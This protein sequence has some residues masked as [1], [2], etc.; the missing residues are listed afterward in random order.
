M[1]GILIKGSTQA[2]KVMVL[3]DTIQLK[4]LAIEP[5]TCLRVEPETAETR[6]SLV[7]IHHLATNFHL[8]AY[9]IYIGSLTR[10]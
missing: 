7:G 10:P 3:A 9:L 2:A 5:E 4:V 6:G 1:K 8:R